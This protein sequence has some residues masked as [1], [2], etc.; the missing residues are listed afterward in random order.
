MEL[1][2]MSDQELHEFG[3]RVIL[4]YI[5]KEDLIIQ[6]VNPDIK[7]NPQIV[8]QRWGSLAYVFVRTDCYPNKGTLS[9]KDFQ[10]CLDWAN[11]HSATAFFASVGVVCVSYPDGTPIKSEAG[12][13]VPYRN[14]G[15]SIGYNGL[16]V[17]TTMDRVRFMGKP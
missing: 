14:G 5:Q 1:S 11:E 3:I 4:P 7:I 17:M 6:G 10:W 12:L 13:S 9:E 15:F 2:V 16:Q 8:G